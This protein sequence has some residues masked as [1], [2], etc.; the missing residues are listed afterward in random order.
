M[1]GGIFMNVV[2]NFLYLVFPKHLTAPIVSV[3]IVVT[4]ALKGLI[5]ESSPNCANLS[6]F[7]EIK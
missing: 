2:W 1:L 7:T 5:K 4:L 6:E 3:C